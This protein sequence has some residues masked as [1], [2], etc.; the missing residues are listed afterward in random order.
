MF[1]IYARVNIWKNLIIKLNFNWFLSRRLSVWAKPS[2]RIKSQGYTIKLAK[3]E[4]ISSNISDK[5]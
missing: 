4:M 5:Y 3:N 2:K 1:K